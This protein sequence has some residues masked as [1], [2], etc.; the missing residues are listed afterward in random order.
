MITL[1]SSICI[2]APPERVW[3]ALS[4]LEDVQVWV[5]VVSSAECGEVTQGVGAKRT[6][7]LKGNI[8]IEET[9][10]AWDE[11]RSFTY[12]A[13]GMPMIRQATNTWT[14]HP[15]GNKTLLTSEAK[16]EVKGGVFGRLLEP[17]IRIQLNRIGPDSL[18]N[19]K[20]LVEYGEPPPSGNS[21]YLPAPA[22][23]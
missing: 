19:F 11:G 17:F 21:E 15:E 3:Q 14:V 23:C 9:W 5:D 22:T 20:Y 1:N 18:A 16:L 13:T 6:C 7:D 12:E 4:Q 2:D 8:T 10:L